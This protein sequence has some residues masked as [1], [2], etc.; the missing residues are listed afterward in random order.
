MKTTKKVIRLGANDSN[1][2][3]TQKYSIGKYRTSTLL[4]LLDEHDCHISEM[5][6]CECVEVW[7]ELRSRGHEGS[8]VL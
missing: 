5:D 1:R 6:G 3:V 4:R 7:A 2:R 8:V